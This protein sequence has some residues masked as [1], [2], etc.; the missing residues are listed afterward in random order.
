[1]IDWNL[2]PG[3]VITVISDLHSNKRAVKAALDAVKKNRTDRLIILGDI[4]TYGIDVEEVME[5]VNNCLINDTIL[6]IGNHDEIYLDLISGETKIYEK[7]R[8]DLQESIAYNLK[9]LDTKQ[10]AGWPWQREITINNVLFS[11]ANPYGNAWEYVKDIYDYQAAALLIK[12]MGHLAGVFG[13]THRSKYFSLN[14]PNLSHIDNLTNDTFILNPG[15]VGQ[16]RSTPR[17]A[18]ILRLSSHK[19][20]L[21]AEIEPVQ[22]DMKE[23]V[24]DLMESSLS[25]STKTIL[26]SFF[27]E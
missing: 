14:D 18:T 7:L 26:A 21:W 24:N 9:K 10:F 13:H 25:D 22:Y 17:Q 15:S 16:P 23:H 12:K 3:E 1:M 27:K 19:N 20:R 8:L 4:L 2:V 11:H 6:L 5:L